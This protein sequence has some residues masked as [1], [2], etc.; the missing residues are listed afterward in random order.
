MRGNT[1]R[2]EGSL[3]EA[4]DD[5][6][7]ACP[8][9]EASPGVATVSEITRTGADG[10]ETA[11]EAGGAES[12]SLFA[13]RETAGATGTESAGFFAVREIAGTRSA[14]LIAVG[15]IGG[16]AVAGTPV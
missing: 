1:R 13:V 8:F 7:T 2:F 11:D 14:G 16:N 15:E 9:R 12:A 6:V 5:D 4:R 3:S 10:W